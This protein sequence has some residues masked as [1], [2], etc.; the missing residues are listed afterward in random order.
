[1]MTKNQTNDREQLEKLTMDHLVP[2]DHLGQKLETA[3]DFSFIYPLIENLYSA[4]GLPSIDPVVLFKGRLFSPCV[5]LSKK[6]NV[7]HYFYL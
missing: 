7:T 5:K 6:L 3:I 1:M 4:N 2:T